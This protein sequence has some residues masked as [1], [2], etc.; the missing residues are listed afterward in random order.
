M[1][2]TKHGLKFRNAWVIYM[3]GILHD[4]SDQLCLKLLKNC[5]SALPEFGR[6]IIVELVVPEFEDTSSSS[7]LNYVMD[8][9]MVMLAAC[10]GGK[11]RSLK[12]FGVLAKE[13]G[14]ATVKFMCNAAVY[15]VLEFHK[16]V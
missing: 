14:F 5:C 16:K 4:W 12:E 15:S 9:D 11:E 8:R 3:Q 10:P 1:S 6:V 7:K 13:S 2:E